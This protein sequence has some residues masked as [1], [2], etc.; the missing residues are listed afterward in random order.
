MNKK[1]KKS[2]LLL[3][4]FFDKAKRID[5]AIKIASKDIR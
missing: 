1:Q 5:N 4:L 3:S 2:G